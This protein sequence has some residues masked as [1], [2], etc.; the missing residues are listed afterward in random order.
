ML[1]ALFM[2][3]RYEGKSLKR[4]INIQISQRTCIIQPPIDLHLIFEK[5]SL[6]NPVG[7]TLYFVYFKLE[8]FEIFTAS[9]L[10]CKNQVR[11]T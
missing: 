7:Q 9:C 5:S 1:Q 8:I 3:L 4:D 6:K 2:L 11:P 10:A